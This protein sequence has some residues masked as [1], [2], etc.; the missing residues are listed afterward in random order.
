M[1]E[2]IKKHQKE[3]NEAFN[4]FG[5]LLKKGKKFEKIGSSLTNFAHKDFFSGAKI[6]LLNHLVWQM[7]IFYCCVQ[8]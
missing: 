7:V 2:L 5:K 6:K 1:K 4:H 8:L 3:F